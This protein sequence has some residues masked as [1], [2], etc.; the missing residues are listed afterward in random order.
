MLNLHTVLAQ[1]Q[2]LSNFDYGFSGDGLYWCDLGEKVGF[3]PQECNDLRKDCK[4]A[5]YQKCWHSKCTA[6]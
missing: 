2:R 4:L 3:F 1:K 5:R 6:G